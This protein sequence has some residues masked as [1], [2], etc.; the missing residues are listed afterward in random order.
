MESQ[1]KS[2]VTW[3]VETDT[4]A[5]RRKLFLHKISHSTAKQFVHL[6]NSRTE[7]SLKAPRVTTFNVVDSFFLM[8][9]TF[10]KSYDLKAASL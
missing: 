2:A 1:T 10:L 4:P 5:I 9:L 6:C 8:L 3:S 7:Q